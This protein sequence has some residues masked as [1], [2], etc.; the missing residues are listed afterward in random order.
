MKYEQY[1]LE[2][3]EGLANECERLAEENAIGGQFLHILPIGLRR[4]AMDQS[5]S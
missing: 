2:E 5:A 1:T 3:I 4:I